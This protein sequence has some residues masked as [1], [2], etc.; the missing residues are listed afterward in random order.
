MSNFELIFFLLPAQVVI[1]IPEYPVDVDSCEVIFDAAQGNKELMNV[2][3]P[4]Y[5]HTGVITNL[6]TSPTNWRYVIASWTQNI[7]KA[8]M[9][10]LGNNL[11]KLKV[12]PTVRAFYGVD[13]SE[14]ILKMAFVF[15]NANGSKVGRNAD[16]SDIFADV[17]PATLS[18]N[19]TSP[20]QRPLMTMDGDSILVAAISPLADSLFILVDHTPVK[21][22]AGQHI[23]DTLP[24]ESFGQ[25]WTK[26]W[27]TILARNDTAA[28]ADSFYYMVLP[29]APIIP[30]PQGTVDGINYIDTSSVILSLFAPEK[31][32][33][34]MIGEFSNWQPDSNF[35]MNKTPDGQ[36]YWIQLQD[37][38]PKQ[39]YLFQ[40]FVDGTLRIGDPYA[41]KVSD[42]NDQYISGTSYP[43]LKPYPFGLTTGIATYLQTAQEPYPWNPVPFNPPDIKSLVI[44]EL[45]IR[46]FTA[47]HTFLS[48]IDTLS[49]LKRLGVNAI[50]LM[51]V[52]E[53][54]G[55]ISW[56][57]NPD[58]SFAVD[59]YYGPKNTL[60]QFVEACHS[61][62]IAVILDIVCNHHFG[63]SPL[64]QLYWD[65]AAQ[66]PAA[67]NPWFN[68][69]PK[70]PYNVG[71]DFNH[72]SDQT[73]VY[74]ERLIKYWIQEYH[75]DGYRFDLSKGFTQV[76]SYPNN[77]ALWGQYDASRISILNNYANVIWSVSPEAYVILEH[78]ADNSEETELSANGM[79]LW[80]NMTGAYGEG[81]KGWNNNG[82]SD[83]SYV[84]YKKRGWSEPHLV[85]YMESHDEERIMFKCISGGNSTQTPYNIKDTST[86]LKRVELG[87]NFFFTVPGPKMIWQFEELGY[88]YS[89]NYPTGTSESR[90]APKPIRWDYQQQWRRKYTYNVFASLAALRKSQPVFSTGDFTTDFV[91]P[92]KRLWLRH[93][94]MNAVVL[95]NF[96]V[97]DR[98][99]VPNFMQT[100]RWYEYYTGDSLD[101]TDISG[102]I[103]F[104]AGEYRL[105]TDKRLPKPIFT[106]L[107]DPSTPSGSGTLFVKIYPNPVSDIIFIDTE[108]TKLDVKISDLAGRTLMWDHFEMLTRYP[109]RLD[110]LKPGIYFICIS[111][112]D[113]GHYTAKIIKH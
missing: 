17:Y 35:Y 100:G 91:P 71:V 97:I 103:F 21:N 76:N 52:M 4:I 85:G 69:V 19:I 42:P 112:P 47:K 73:R 94:S 38:V 61:K 87:A 82:K 96:D 46:D 93:S 64:V 79:M 37:L 77:V 7:P 109:L 34:F 86:A 49:Y 1:T 20:A 29:P 48:L 105:Y 15:R 90:L 113:K 56:G 14:Q 40:Y 53:F 51:P 27:I 104:R 28:A 95:G 111:N 65:G 36:R 45:L 3:P 18:V 70:H 67:N 81:A 75:V 9:E 66:R 68:Q 92:V 102:P 98:D 12:T 2:P 43:N 6:S 62:G 22:T 106:G 78:F 32:F 33:C 54:E 88:D 55:N 84:S 101:V 83:L 30:L 10:P 24:A 57:Y 39:E 108:E 31:R 58:F 59:K 110:F 8:L 44:Y 50:E 107:D 26:H 23:S 63:Q 80:G 60:K 5:A 74:M 11:Y 89:I 13:T 25:Y 99:V 72:E 16:G 41:D